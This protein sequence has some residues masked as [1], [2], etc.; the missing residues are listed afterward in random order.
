MRVLGVMEVVVVV[1][2]I[3][4]IWDIFIFLCCWT[5][6][7][8]AWSRWTSDEWHGLCDTDCARK[9]DAVWVVYWL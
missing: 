3:R 5:R 6:S 7:S 2:A 1:V 9:D 4:V 8:W